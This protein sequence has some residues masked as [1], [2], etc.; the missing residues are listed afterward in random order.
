[1]KREEVIHDS[2]KAMNKHYFIMASPP[3]LPE[4]MFCYDDS[5]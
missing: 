5:S 2:T 1:M 4:M 3:G